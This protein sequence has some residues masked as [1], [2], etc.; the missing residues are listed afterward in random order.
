MKAVR[1]LTT[2]TLAAAATVALALAPLAA[3]AQA[4]P[5][6][7]LRM[8]VPF[9][10]GGGVD[11]LGRLLG[12]KLSERL[13]QPV[14]VENRVGAGG[15]LGAEHVARSRPDGS[16]LLMSSSSISISPSL[17]SK[18]G[19]T[20]EDFAPVS[21]VAQIPIVPMVRSSLQIR[22]LKEF[23]DYARANPGKLTFGSSGVGATTSLATELF[24]INM[25]I[26]ILHVP[27]KGTSQALTGL[28][29]GE[30]DMVMTGLATAV[31]QVQTGK[32]R[33][34]AIMDAKRAASLPDVP[35]ARENGISDCDTTTWFGVLAAAGT[36]RPVVGR[37]NKELAGIIAAPD[38]SEKMKAA[39]VEPFTSTPEQFGEFMKTETA[40]WARLVRETNMPK[41]D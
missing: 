29:G 26:D 18:L 2:K 15:N 12:P 3:Q 5:D 27:Y 4:F 10:P 16:T 17:Y 6:R 32:V 28:M 20:I 34:I 21:L 1:I 35:T 36:P 38:I 23:V 14:L 19:Y 30:V 25:K 7:P 31:Q 11:I 33:A 40:R 13:G 41:I 9:P 22:S 8:V 37:L 24:R 39:G